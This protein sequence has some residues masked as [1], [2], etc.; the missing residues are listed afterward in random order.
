MIWIHNLCYAFF[1][2]D[3]D[4]SG[5]VAFLFNRPSLGVFV[6][7]TWFQSPVVSLTLWC[8]RMMPT[9]SRRKPTTR[10]IPW[11]AYAWELNSVKIFCAENGIRTCEHRVTKSCPLIFPTIYVTLVFGSIPHVW[12][13][14][15]FY[16]N[17]TVDDEK[18]LE[19]STLLGVYT[20]QF[21]SD[22]YRLLK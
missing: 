13:Y 5:S 15:V 1:F 19:L 20:Y 8:S 14:H 17:K 12:L 18:W 4:H 2:N 9:R 21:M 10:K 6:P 22:E 16:W 11:L 7:H 3:D